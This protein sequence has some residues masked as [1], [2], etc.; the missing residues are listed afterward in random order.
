MATAISAPATGKNGVGPRWWTSTPD[1]ATD[2]GKLP[3]EQSISIPITRPSSPGETHF[4][5]TVSTV[6]LPRPLQA[7]ASAERGRGARPLRPGKGPG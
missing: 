4:C 7:P 5:K 2:S 3:N 1:T 6:T